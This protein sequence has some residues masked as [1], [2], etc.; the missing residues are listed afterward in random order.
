MFPEALKRATRR[1]KA[2]AKQA[3]PEQPFIPLAD[4]LRYGLVATSAGEPTGRR[5]APNAPGGLKAPDADPDDG[6]REDNSPSDR[7]PKKAKLGYSNNEIEDA[8]RPFIEEY[9]LVTR[10]CTIARQGANVGSDFVASDGR[11]IEVKAFGGS[12]PDSV[13]FQASEWRRA[14]QP[15]AAAEYWLYVVEHL[16]DGQPPRITAV[17]NPVVDNGTVKRRPGSS[18]SAVGETQRSSITGNSATA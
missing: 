6:K 8:A 5:P 15:E 2:E 9:E 10:G 17:L 13:D 18:G 7:Q 11:F 1:R 12:A 16:R 3:K 4:P 14:Q